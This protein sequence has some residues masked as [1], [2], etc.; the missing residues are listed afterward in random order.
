MI[1]KVLKI[2]SAKGLAEGELDIDASRKEFKK[3]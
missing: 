2:E 1:I 3:Y